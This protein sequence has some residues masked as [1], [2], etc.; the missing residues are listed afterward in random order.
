MPAPAPGQVA[1]AAHKGN[2]VIPASGFGGDPLRG[3]YAGYP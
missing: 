2:R 3:R 1:L